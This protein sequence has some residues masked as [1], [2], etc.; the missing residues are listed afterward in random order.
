MA[1]HIARP[2]K[3]A[4]NRVRNRG[5]ASWSESMASIV[6][7]FI[8]TSADLSRASR[9]KVSENAVGS[10]VVRA[11]MLKVNPLNPCCAVI[12]VAFRQRLALRAELP[13]IANHADNRHAFESVERAKDRSAERVLVAKRFPNQRLIHHGDQRPLRRIAIAEVASAFNGSS[14][15]RKRARRDDGEHA[16]GARVQSGFA[17]SRSMKYPPDESMDPGGAMVA[18][19]ATT[20]GS[21]PI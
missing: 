10:P 19:A 1:R 17:G 4:S 13:H 15:S 9:R 20:P 21:L 12:H 8:G 3:T 18:P 7:N 14:Q 16:S 11:T 2:A 5:A 6:V